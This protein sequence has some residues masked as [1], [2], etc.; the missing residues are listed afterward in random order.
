[1]IL[2]GLFGSYASGRAQWVSRALSSAA[3]LCCRWTPLL[4]SMLFS[5]LHAH[6][7]ARCSVIP[8]KWHHRLQGWFFAGCA[9]LVVVMIGLLKN[10]AQRAYGKSEDVRFPC[11]HLPLLQF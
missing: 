5:R 6:A 11:H 4:I 2:T 1:M 7:S 9:F 8:I 10:G 3:W